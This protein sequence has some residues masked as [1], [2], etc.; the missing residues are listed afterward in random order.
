M[1]FINGVWINF[2]LDKY[3]MRDT[4]TVDQIECVSG[5]SAVRTNPCSSCNPHSLQ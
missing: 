5:A 1:G 4:V 3:L 2:G